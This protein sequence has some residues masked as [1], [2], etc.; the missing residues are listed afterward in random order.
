[1]TEQNPNTKQQQLSQKRIW[2]SSL[3]GLL[4]T[5]TP[6][7]YTQRWKPLLWFLGGIFSIA[8]VMEIIAPTDSFKKSFERGSKWSVVTTAVAITDNWIAISRA[9]K[10]RKPAL[11]EGNLEDES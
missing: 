5:F 3:L 2:I 9:R 1:M 11:G 8:F 10:Q 4:I 7:L 6:Y